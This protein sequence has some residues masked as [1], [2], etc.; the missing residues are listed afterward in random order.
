[1]SAYQ[2]KVVSALTIDLDYPSKEKQE[3]VEVDLRIE[4]KKELGRIVIADCKQTSYG[5]NNW[6]L[7]ASNELKC[8]D[9]V[10]VHSE[11]CGRESDDCRRE[12]DWVERWKLDLNDIQFMSVQSGYGTDIEIITTKGIKKNI[13]FNDS[14]LGEKAADII[15]T[16]FCK[17][18]NK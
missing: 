12:Y 7:I 11:N 2:P 17:G 14:E 5:F 6:M 1:M 16:F 9:Y 4:A 15:Y 10:Y 3:T 13:K 18:C 8:E